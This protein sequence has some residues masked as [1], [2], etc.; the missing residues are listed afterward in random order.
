M[1]H[2]KC[3]PLSQSYYF[4]RFCVRKSEKKRAR[5]HYL[6]SHYF[7]KKPDCR[8]GTEKWC[9]RKS[10]KG[11]KRW[12]K[13]TLF[14]FF[15]EVMHI[16]NVWFYLIKTI[17]CE[18][19]AMRKMIKS[20]KGPKKNE[21]GCQNWARKRWKSSPPARRPETEKLRFFWRQGPVASADQLSAG[22]PKTHTIQQDR[23]KTSCRKIN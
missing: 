15:P 4:D 20:K 3:Q 23:I 9:K 11:S 8:K 19:G 2:V 5:M 16:D 12:P 21:K 1:K 6:L 18:A 14:G 17:H 22:G 10:E 7:M 13:I